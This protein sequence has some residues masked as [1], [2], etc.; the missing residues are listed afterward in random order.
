[1][2]VGREPL[3]CRS[4]WER[5]NL[6]CGSCKR[7]IGVE[8]KG[9]GSPPKG[10]Y[11]GRKEETTEWLITKRKPGELANVCPAES[12]L[13]SLQTAFAATSEGSARQPPAPMGLWTPAYFACGGLLCAARLGA[14][15]TVPLCE[16]RGRTTASARSARFWGA[17]EAGFLPL[18]PGGVPLCRA[19][20]QTP[21]VC[22]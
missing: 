2:W 20:P 1:M 17:V 5:V 7:R 18:L 13:G 6:C 10:A 9:K 16:V 3:C 4:S 12:W 19:R 15:P 14:A 21:A 8:R 22:H 11:R